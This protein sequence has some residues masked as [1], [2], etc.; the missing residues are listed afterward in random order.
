VMRRSVAL[1]VALM[2]TLPAQ[3]NGGDPF[4]ALNILR[5]G[6]TTAAADFSVPALAGP[7]LRLSDFKGKVVLLNFWATWCPPCKE[8]M[9]S[10]ERLYRRY[11]DKGFAILA[12]SIDA[13]G[14][15]PVGPFARKLGLTFPIGL[16]A[17]QAVA[18]QYGVPA[19][20]A[21]FLIDRAGNTAGV[22]LGPRDWDT[23]DAHAVVEAL[24]QC[25]R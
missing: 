3:V 1:L 7:A 4:P 18:S 16:D 6:R 5:P 8:E 19:L 12:I 10:M 23:R 17:K 25:L 21:S 20:P 11:K 15:G 9:P 24:L 13:G 22:A 14:A 2:T